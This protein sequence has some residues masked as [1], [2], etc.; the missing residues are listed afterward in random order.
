LSLLFGTYLQYKLSKKHG[1]MKNYYQNSKTLTKRC[2]IGFLILFTSSLSIFSQVQV[3]V[4]TDGNPYTGASNHSTWDLATNDLQAA[5]DGAAAGPEGG[6]IWVASGTYLPTTVFAAIPIP[7]NPPAGERHQSFVMRNNATVIGGFQGNE[8]TLEE[9]PA[10]FLDPANATILSGDVGVAL[11]ITDNSYH[12]VIFP[13][14]SDE[15]A[16]LQEVIITG[17]NA[18]GSSDYYANRGGGVHARNGGLVSHCKIITNSAS[19]YGGGAYLFEGCTIDQSEIANNQASIDGGGVFLNLG[20]Q[21]A[22][23][24]IHSNSADNNGGGIFFDSN[25]TSA[26]TLTHSFV[27]GNTANKG[28]GVGTYEGG[29]IINNFIANNS[30]E[31]NGGGIYLQT[32]GFVLNNTVV[33][34]HGD[35]GAGI[36]GDVGGNIIHSVLWGNTTPYA[37]NNQFASADATTL[38]NYSAIQGGTTAEGITNLV[39]LDPENTGTDI[40]PEF[41]NPISFSGPPDNQTEIDEIRYSDYRINLESALLDAGNPDLSGLPI[42]PYDLTPNE[43]VIKSVIDIG[44]FEALYYTLTSSVLSGTGNIDPSGTVNYLAGENLNF[45][46]NP[47]T[48]MDIASF[49]INDDEY[50]AQLTENSGNFTYTYSNIADDLTATVDFGIINLLENRIDGQFRIFPVPAKTELTIEGASIK[51]YQ[52]YSI[53]GKPVNNAK[54]TSDTKINI[55]RLTKGLYILKLIDKTDNEHTVRFIKE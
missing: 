20:G 12:V 44:A 15:T 8:S 35:H 21:V 33:G 23:T 37:S 28:G 17:G 26:G 16:V 34:N 50:L 40:N 9:R 5:I 53:D 55:S 18:N 48:N 49:L 10:D 52:I 31:G 39:S 43:R 47:G 45:T 19:E 2:L 29:N 54:N 14:G 27:I 41:R 13:L 30:S 36:Y 25:N 46:I 24:L 42:P 32:A 51:S 6:I 22:Q 1:T 3:M 7:P 38:V 4:A 11:D